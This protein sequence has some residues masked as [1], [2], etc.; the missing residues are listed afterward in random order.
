EEKHYKKNKDFS[1][2]VILLIRKIKKLK[3]IEK[4]KSKKKELRKKGWKI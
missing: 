3:F 1:Y 4:I 2:C